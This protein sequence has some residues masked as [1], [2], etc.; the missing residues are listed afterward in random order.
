[1]KQPLI[2]LALAGLGLIGATMLL[3]RRAQ[4]ANQSQ[5]RL[6]TG[7][8][9]RLARSI[10]TVA[11][12]VDGGAALLP[13]SLISGAGWASHQAARAAGV[14]S[15]AAG[16]A[17]NSV[18]N[19]PAEGGRRSVSFS[20][21]R[22]RSC[23]ISRLIGFDVRWVG[24]IGALVSCFSCISKMLSASKIYCPVSK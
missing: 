3:H 21:Q 1:M 14:Q 6:E 2:L 7:Y 22:R 20:R 12:G 11:I 13:S 24:G 5:D 18:R 16:V 17:S 23:S 4:R 8:S 10:R 19:S 9:I 15:A